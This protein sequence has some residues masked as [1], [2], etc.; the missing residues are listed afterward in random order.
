METRSRKMGPGG[1]LIEEE[2]LIVIAWTL[3]M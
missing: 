2:D 1:V 3:A